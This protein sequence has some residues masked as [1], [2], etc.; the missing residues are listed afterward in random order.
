MDS[1][2]NGRILAIATT[3]AI[4]EIPCL[5]MNEKDI[6]NK[7]FLFNL[8]LNAYSCQKSAFL[9]GLRSGAWQM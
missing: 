2:G 6:D 3:D 4:L 1:A 8:Q 5:G 9:S 7:F